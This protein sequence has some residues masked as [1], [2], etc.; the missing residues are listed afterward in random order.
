MNFYYNK[1]FPPHLFHQF[2][3]YFLFLYQIEEIL[4]RYLLFSKEYLDLILQA[5]DY[6]LSHNYF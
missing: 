6:Q 4:H 3:F 1:I 2:F 5:L